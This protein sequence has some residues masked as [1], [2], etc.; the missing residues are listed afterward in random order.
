MEA[1]LYTPDG[2]GPFPSVIV[3]HTSQGLI[4]TTAPIAPGGRRRLHLI[5]PAFLRAT[6]S[7]RTPEATFTTDREALLAD[8]RQISTSSTAPQARRAPSA[9]RL[10]EGGFSRSPAGGLRQDQGRRH[11][12]R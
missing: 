10:L 11:S 1:T 3:L 2:P 5:V 12:A 4:E 9:R 6:V 7:A 8:F